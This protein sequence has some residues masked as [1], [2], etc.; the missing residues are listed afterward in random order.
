MSQ[1]A[2][3]PDSQDIVV[4]TLLIAGVTEGAVTQALRSAGLK[5][6]SGISE[7]WVTMAVRS[8]FEQ[9]AMQFPIKDSR[10]NP[11]IRD[12]FQETRRRAAQL[13]EDVAGI[14]RA[15]GSREFQAYMTRVA[16]FDLGRLLD[17]HEELVW[18]SRVASMAAKDTKSW[19]KLY[20]TRR[21]LKL[22]VVALAPVFE[23]SFGE[24]VMVSDDVENASKFVVF[25]TA[26]LKLAFG[27]HV[28]ADHKK[29]WG[30]G[31]KW[32]ETWPFDW[33]YSAVVPPPTPYLQ[34]P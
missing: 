5:L 18:F 16:E 31:R 25:H 32:K 11:V 15:P 13:A 21:F 14:I 7:S 24:E 4:E 8:V 1:E 22:T 17:L 6:Q 23:Q 28:G 2:S 27:T 30:A 10:S 19:T 12:G 34:A 20:G 9:V 26:M 29:I 3:E 33:E